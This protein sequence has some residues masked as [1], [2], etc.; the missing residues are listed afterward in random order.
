[1]ADIIIYFKDGSKQEFMHSGRPGGSYTKRVK[2]E[3]NF[4]IITDEYYRQTAFPMDSIQK[5]E[6]I[7]NYC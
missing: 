2:Y 4:A 5:V 6:S 7:P 3:G 1:M